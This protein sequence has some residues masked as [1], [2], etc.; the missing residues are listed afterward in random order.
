VFGLELESI[1]IEDL[2]SMVMA[3]TNGVRILSKRSAQEIVSE[4]EQRLLVA[5]YGLEDIRSRPGRVR[6]GL[7]NVIVFGRA[8][9]FGLQHLRGVVADFDAWYI[10][11]QEAMR[12]H[13][14]MSYFHG[15]RNKI[16]KEAKAVPIK[17]AFHISHLRFPQDFGDPPPGASGVFVGDAEGGSGWFIETSEGSTEKYYIE[18]PSHMVQIEIGMVGAPSLPGNPTPSAFELASIYVHELEAILRDARQKYAPYSQSP[19]LR[20]P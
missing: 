19:W 7:A 9:T 6:S 8:V 16:E 10:P 17:T 20:K 4:A 2:G 3:A 18:V 1:R 13:P 11:L 5:K 15:L 14:V 12:K